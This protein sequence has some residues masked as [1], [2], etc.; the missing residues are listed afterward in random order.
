MGKGLGLL[1]YDTAIDLGTANTRIYVRGQ[2]LVLDEP[3][4]VAVQN[5]KVVAAGAE[6]RRMLGRT[7]MGVQVQRP[8]RD[9]VVADY[10]LA[11][12]MLRVFLLR[13]QR[14]GRLVRPRVAI[15]VP[16]GATVV[17]RR[18]VEEAAF[19]AG[20]RSVHLVD[21]PMAAA[22]GCGLAIEEPAAVLVAD[23]GAGATDV[24]IISMGGMVASHTARTGGDALDH[25][26]AAYV[27][28]EHGMLVGDVTAEEAKTGLTGTDGKAV[29]RGRYAATGLPGT[30][31]LPYEEVQTALAEPMG[32][33]MNAVRLA[34]DVC[35]PELS[36]DLMDRGLVLTGGAAMTAGLSERLREET[37]LPVQAADDPFGAV[38]LGTARHLEALDLFGGTKWKTRRTTPVA[39]F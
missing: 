22:I 30:L 1:G 24:A 38:V 21:A 26:L 8:L 27:R 34:L 10:S 9:G 5:G 35:P 3:S 19:A 7:P 11:R 2:G 28:G 6:A 12:R 23:V 13:V 14:W 25:A 16:C 29:I 4:V 37:D 20:A 36:G 15:T 33:I 32:S 18:A 17:E 31:T 39:A